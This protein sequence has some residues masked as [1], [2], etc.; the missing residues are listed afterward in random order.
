MGKRSD[1]ERRDRDYY[2]TPKEAVLPLFAHLD[3]N[4]KFIEPCAGDLALVKI[5]EEQGHECVFASDIEPQAPNVLKQDALSSTFNLNPNEIIV[6]NP[7]W[8]RKVLHPMIVAFSNVA[9]TWLL[10]DADWMHTKQ[11]K[12]YLPRLRKIISVGRVKWIPES[13]GAGKDNSAWYLFDKPS[14]IPTIFYG[15]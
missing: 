15:R 12:E 5:L 2:P 6:T 7:P 14:E 10:F 1:F 13:N 3:P 11:S 4:T 9:P 8:D